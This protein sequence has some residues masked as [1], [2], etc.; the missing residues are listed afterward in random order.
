[1][2][3]ARSDL[4]VIM[5]LTDGIPKPVNV[6]RQ[7]LPR[8]ILV[9]SSCTGAGTLEFALEDRMCLPAR[10]RSLAAWG[11]G[12]SRPD[13]NPRVALLDAC[14]Q[15]CF[16]DL[17][18][19][20]GLGVTFKT[21][22]ACDSEPTAKQFFMAHHD[23]NAF[24]DDANSEEHIHAPSTDIYCAGWPCQ[25]LSTCGSMGGE[26][27]ARTQVWKSVVAHVEHAQPRA[28]LSLLTTFQGLFA[29]IMKRLRAIQRDGEP[30]YE[31][32]F[33]VMNT[34]VNGAAQQRRRVYIV[35]LRRDSIVSSFDWPK[36]MKKPELSKFLDDDFR[37]GKLALP[38]FGGVT[39]CNN[40]DAVY[41]ACEEKGLNPKH[42][43]IIV[44][45]GGSK[46]HYY[47]GHAPTLTASR[48]GWW[49]VK[50]FRTCQNSERV[51]AVPCRISDVWSCVT[52]GP[53]RVTPCCSLSC[54][55]LC[56]LSRYGEVRFSRLLGDLT[57]PSDGRGGALQA[58][59][60]QGEPSRH[61]CSE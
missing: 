60:L 31:V 1:M 25:G 27:D 26:Q 12:L 5:S 37:A 58:P 18:N 38:T 54:L 33:K 28:P 48:R 32:R 10:R 17:F 45:C 46:P 11:W 14:F 40:V 39:A 44:D 30:C 36:P 35:G 20:A 19:A 15:A 23:C 16:I 55:P 3:Q 21:A 22:F 53:G 13:A 34:I 8:S 41:K 61:A 57:Q 6:N 56:L 9:G 50:L 59:G 4:E 43:D 52:L 2:K 51:R 7:K 42:H 29:K 24:Y 47:I 49:V